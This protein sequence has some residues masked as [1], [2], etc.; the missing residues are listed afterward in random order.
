MAFYTLD[1]IDFYYIF[2][3]IKFSKTF[4]ISE[5]RR[6]K[7]FLARKKMNTIYSS[8]DLFFSLL[9][10]RFKPSVGCIDTLGQCD[11]QPFVEHARSVVSEENEM[12]LCLVILSVRVVTLETDVWTLII[13]SF[14]LAWDSQVALQRAGRSGKWEVDWRWV[15]NPVLVDGGFEDC[16]PLGLR[17]LDSSC[18]FFVHTWRDYYV[19]PFLF[20]Q[21]PLV[22]FALEP[23]RSRG[24]TS[25]TFIILFS[26]VQCPSGA[27]TKKTRILP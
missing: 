20:A 8:R 19:Q 18:K 17:Q 16:S 11:P 26:Y 7:T 13:L 12:Y 24:T 14:T 1:R 15:I 9:I 25:Y 2:R 10:Y 3:F 21:H 5:P 23:S 6:T 4:Y 27:F 22:F